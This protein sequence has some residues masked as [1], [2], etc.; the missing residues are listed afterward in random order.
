[1]AEEKWYYEK[2]SEKGY[3]KRA[4]LNDPDGKI[5]GRHVFGLKAWFDENPEER[6]RLG[7]VKHITHPTKDIEYDKSCQY[8]VNSPLIIDAHT[9]E[10]NW[11]IMTMSPEQMRLAETGTGVE[12]LMYN[13][14][15]V[16]ES[17][18]EDEDV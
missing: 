17:W 5:T 13:D 9:V 14:S 1:M 6:I 8:L 3:K 4:P 10:D 15:I 2:L 18:W 16:W 12:S 11:Q 7:W